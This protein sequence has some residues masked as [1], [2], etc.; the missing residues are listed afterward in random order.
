LTEFEDVAVSLSGTSYGAGSRRIEDHLRRERARRGDGK[1]NGCE[2]QNQV[3]F[4]RGLPLRVLTAS[5]EAIEVMD[6]FVKHPSC[7][8]LTG[9]F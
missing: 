8:Q 1:S 9:C 4:H 5:H 7:Q 6:G 2:C 3:T